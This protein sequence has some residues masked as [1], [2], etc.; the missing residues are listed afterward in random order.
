VQVLPSIRQELLPEQTSGI[1]EPRAEPETA[2]LGFIHGARA[3][4]CPR[5]A[6]VLSVTALDPVQTSEPGC[7][8]NNRPEWFGCWIA[9]VIVFSGEFSKGTEEKNR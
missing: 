5:Q 2:W 3:G 1:V 7:P 6:N 4:A 8:Q 9:K